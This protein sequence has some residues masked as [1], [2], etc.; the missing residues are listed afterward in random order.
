MASS[1]SDSDVEGPSQPLKRVR[2]PSEWKQNVNKRKKDKGEAYIS[3]ATN[4]LVSSRKIGRPCT[5]PRRCFEKVGDD[6]VKQLFS[7]FYALGDYNAQ[8][9]YIHKC[10][11]AMPVKRVRVKDSESRR[12]STRIHTVS[13]GNKSITVCKQAFVSIHGITESRVRHVIEKASASGSANILPDDQ[14]GHHAAANKTSDEARQFVLNFIRAL[15]TCSS[16]YSRA[17]SPNRMYLPPGSTFKGV[18]SAYCEAVTEKKVQHL[19]VS[20]FVFQ[21]ILK[22]F[23]IGVEPPRSDTCNFCDEYKIKI[24]KLVKGRDDA[25][26]LRLHT[27]RVPHICHAKIAQRFLK[28]FGE[29]KSDA[30][31]VIAIDLQQTLA[32]PRLTSG[33]QYYKRKLWTYNLGIH[34]CKAN[35]AYFYVWNESKAKR[36]SSEVCSC[37]DHYV[38]NYVGE[39]VNKLII[40]SDNC[41]G[42]NKNINVVL[43]YLRWVHEGRF[44][45]VEHYFMEPGHSYLPC[46]RDFGNLEIALKGHEVYSTP[47]YVSFMENARPNN[48]V[49]V[50]EMQ[51]TDFY[52]FSV[53]QQN[54]TKA[55]QKGSGFKNAK[56]FLVNSEDKR[57]LKVCAGFGEFHP[58]VFLKLQKGRG[59]AYRESFNL[60][61]IHLPH[62]YPNGVKIDTSKLEDIKDLIRFIPESHKSFYD[63]LLASQEQM[64]QGEMG[65]LSQEDDDDDFLEY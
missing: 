8:S 43:C 3:K 38:R 34:D 52:D 54:C 35:K 6:N 5:C 60:S 39:A 58:T 18:Y 23:N 49:I 26:I 59:N 17:K 48:P 30:L 11:K 24:S 53:L 12:K 32:T 55:G 37:V 14:R 64:G 20:N 61:E 2:N 25:E 46:D 65:E 16:H 40:F 57:G 28:T 47:H 63:Q 19:K 51:A 4:K 42:Q 10:V 29:D 13:V 21:G 9:H 44:S 22:E 33:A 41:A 15:P 50:V 62:K 1:G 36:G 27:E 56:R 45:N 31:A 7:D